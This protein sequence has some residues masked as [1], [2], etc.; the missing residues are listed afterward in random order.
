M[1]M[2]SPPSAVRSTCGSSMATADFYGFPDRGSGVKVAFHHGGETTSVEGLRRDVSTADVDDVRT[3]VRRFVPAADGRVRASIVC[4]YTNTADGN[5]W[6]DRHPGHPSVLVASPCSGITASS[7]LSDR[8][9]PCRSR[10]A[11]AVAVR[12][13][14]LPL[15]LTSIAAGPAGLTADRVRPPSL[16]VPCPER[17]GDRRTGG[18][19]IFLRPIDIAR[20]IPRIARRRH[21]V[22][23]DAC[24][25]PV[26]PSRAANPS[27]RFSFHEDTEIY[28]QA[29]GRDGTVRHRVR[30]GRGR[31]GRRRHHAARRA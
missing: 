17:E 19:P 16:S 28:V 6:I 23:S 4:M 20:R 9:D 3:A 11:A 8:R 2:R 25:H 7:S 24:R 18:P 15:A 12:S 1:R 10:S 27:S 26:R 30:I 22:R 14:R 5:F 13:R 31:Q 21:P 29:R